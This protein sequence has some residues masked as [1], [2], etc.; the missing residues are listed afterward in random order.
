MARLYVNEKIPSPAVD[1]P[2]RLGHDLLTMPEDGRAG[3]SVPDDEVLRRAR[4][5][6]RAVLTL[7]RKHF[8]RLHAH[9]PD[10]AGSV[11][12]SFDPDFPAL[13]R[14]V[15]RS[16]SEVAPLTGRLLRVNRPS[17]TNPIE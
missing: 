8:I 10:H 11:V 15:D 14:R 3:K 2:R 17:G 9:R 4:D 16:L 6:G 5:Q 1:E 13:A 12:C 7:N